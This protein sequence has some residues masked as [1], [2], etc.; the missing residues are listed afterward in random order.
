MAE[1]TDSFTEKVKSTA[2]NSRMV[3][4]FSNIKGKT[5]TENTEKTLEKHSEASRS[6]ETLPS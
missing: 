2:K 6:V 5:E 3:V 1:K 4:R